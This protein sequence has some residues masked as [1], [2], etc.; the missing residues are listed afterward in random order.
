MVEVILVMKPSALHSKVLALEANWTI[1]IMP[2]GGLLF[3]TFYHSESYRQM[4]LKDVRL[5]INESGVKA[6]TLGGCIDEI[7]V[8]TEITEASK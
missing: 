7:Y 2:G 8:D 5:L 3:R 1:E 6:W 4:V